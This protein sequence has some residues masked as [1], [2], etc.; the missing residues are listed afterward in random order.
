MGMMVKD[1]FKMSLFKDAKL[2]AGKNGLDNEIIWI[3]LMEIIDSFHSLVKG[4]FLF[5]SA[6]GFNDER[7]SRD[8]ISKLKNKGISG[9]GIQLGYYI[10]SIPEHMIIE[11]DDL[12]FPL[13]HIPIKIT[14]SMITRTL[15]KELI[16]YN[17]EEIKYKNIT[18]DDYILIDVLENKKINSV[19]MNYLKGIVS[20]DDKNA[21][22]MIFS[23][24]HKYDGI[25]LRTDVEDSMNKIINVLR[26]HDCM[27]H[28]EVIRGNYLILLNLGKGDS[29]SDIQRHIDYE[30]NSLSDLYNNLIF[31]VSISSK[32]SNVESIKKSYYEAMSSQ[33]QL[34]KINC[35]KGV[36]SFENSDF[37]NLFIKDSTRNEMIEFSKKILSPIKAYDKDMNTN[38]FEMLEV[39]LIN[40]CN[41]TKTSENLYVHRHTM[42]NK[43][44]KMKL[45]FSI[46]YL[47]NI[48]LLKYR[49]A[50]FINNLYK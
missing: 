4:E 20:S 41:I 2:I 13:V 25:I 45:L 10:D 43:L 5:T 32:F 3:N 40:N 50:Y 44:E 11:A 19:R 28:K 39:Y 23:V 16:N 26:L 37:L 7:I 6:Y 14:F 1:L 27:I 15:Y 47:D 34:S 36:I 8:L 18:K 12:G 31:I 21:Y 42:K 35:S 49:F 30:L 22:L 38:Y 29:I 9:L 48:T 46:D 17:V 24:F 33:Q